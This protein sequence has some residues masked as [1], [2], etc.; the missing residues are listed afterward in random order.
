LPPTPRSEVAWTLLS[1][2]ADFRS[3]LV[4]YYWGGGYRN[5]P[6][7]LVEETAEEIRIAI[8]LPD[9]TKDPRTEV[10]EL[11]AAVGGSRQS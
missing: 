2:G 10:I 11:F 5:E 1:V 8:T 7:V 3:L 9:L 6:E 4:A